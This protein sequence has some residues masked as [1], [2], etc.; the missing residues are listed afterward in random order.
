[1]MLLLQNLALVFGVMSLIVAGWQDKNSRIAPAIYLTPTLFGFAYNPLMGLFGL[2]LTICLYK[3]WTDE[4]NKYIGLGDVLLTLSVF[5]AIFNSLVSV[6]F[7]TVLFFVVI[8][9][10]I[11]SKE[12]KVPVIWVLTKWL[13]FILSIYAMVVIIG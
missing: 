3:F 7:I 4:H 9:L 8:E 13:T 12:Q 11:L 2:I 6:L 10:I 5:F 1:M